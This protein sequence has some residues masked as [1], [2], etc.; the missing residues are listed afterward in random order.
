MTTSPRPSLPGTP[1]PGDLELTAGDD[2]V[3]RRHRADDVPGIVAQCIDPVSVEYTI[4]P[5][6]Y[7]TEQAEAF[8]AMCRRDWEAGTAAAFAVV[9]DGRFAGTVDLQ[10]REAGWAEVGFGLGPW[11][12]GRGVG[13]RA[14]RRV[15]RWG[16]DDLGLEGVH[17]RAHV[18]NHA[19]RRTAERCGVRVEGEVR[20]LLVQRGRR[21]DGWIGSVRRGDDLEPAV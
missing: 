7:G 2:L 11:A 14:V 8:V 18:G 15:L 12:R 13:V 3:L 4:V 17:W 5:T 19:T 21:R 1:A 16:F 10:L 6:P 9:V 20:G